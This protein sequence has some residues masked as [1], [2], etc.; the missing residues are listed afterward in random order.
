MLVGW[1]DRCGVGGSSAAETATALLPE[2][3]RERERETRPHVQI[4]Y[5]LPRLQILSPLTGRGREG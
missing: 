4:M 2:R 3:E 1:K 5:L